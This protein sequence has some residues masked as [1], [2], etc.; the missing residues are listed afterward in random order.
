MYYTT[1]Q[2]TDGFG[3][4][5]QNIIFNILYA[6]YHNHTYVYT[7]LLSIDH[8]YDN[9]SNFNEKLNSFMNLADT[10][11]RPNDAGTLIELYTEY[12]SFVQSII[13]SLIPSNTFLKIKNAFFSNKSSPFTNDYLN[14]SVHVRRPNI[15]DDRLDGADTPDTYYLDVMNKIRQLKLNKSI[16]FHI[17][18]QGNSDMF[19][20]YK[21][22]DVEFHLNDTIENT[23]LGLVYADILVISKSSFSYTAGLLTDGLVIYHPGFWHPPLESWIKDI[24]NLSENNII[25]NT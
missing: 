4:I 22:D 12:Y 15:C 23:F 20:A 19:S 7:P 3:A 25:C 1:I 10:F 6:E 2:R 16:K 9:I 11:K 14:I 8:N 5:F 24:N 13:D 18:S 17:Y 21:S